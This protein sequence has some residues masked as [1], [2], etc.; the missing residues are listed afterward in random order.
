MFL[1]G[2]SLFIYSLLAVFVAIFL[3]II[4]YLISQSIENRLSRQLQQRENSYSSMSDE[5]KYSKKTVIQTEI[6]EPY[7]TFPPVPIPRKRSNQLNRLLLMLLTLFTLIL[8]I[9]FKYV[10]ENYP[11]NEKPGSERIAVESP[12]TTRE[13]TILWDV[14]SYDRLA[15]YLRQKNWEA[16]DKETYE[17]LLKLAGDK[18]KARGY[19]DLNEFENLPCSDLIKLDDLWREASDGKLG[20][21][22]QQ[23]IYKNQGL[24][25]QQM[26]AEVKWAVFQDENFVL[27][28]DRQLNWETR[29][30]EYKLGMEP[31]FKNPPPGHLP[32]TIGTVRGKEFPQFAELCGF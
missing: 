7:P 31:N 18:S 29:K 3:L 32:V 2:S 28:V 30:L 24:D 21:S 6:S 22:A 9:S 5:K 20:F 8:P 25:W 4:L 15:L 14:A 23:I 26:Y 27:L 16:A 12:S 11:L 1:S 19:I 10:A 17:L 13:P